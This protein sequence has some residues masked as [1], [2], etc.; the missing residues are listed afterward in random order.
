MPSGKALTTCSRARTSPR[1][2]S[3]VASAKRRCG[4]ESAVFVAVDG[5]SLTFVD[6]TGERGLGAVGTYT[7]GACGLKV[8]TALA[9]SDG[10]V[11]IGVLRQVTWR[12]ASKRP[13]NRRSANKRPDSNKETRHRLEAVNDSAARVAATGSRTRMTYLVDREGDSAAMLT[14][15]V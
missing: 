9:I 4:Q 11:P 1:P 2:H 12:R 8:I 6:K 10:G 13:T 15:L 5:S 7:A 3:S 14:T